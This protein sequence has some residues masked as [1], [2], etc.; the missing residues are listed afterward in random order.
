MDLVN[1]KVVVTEAAT[2][3]ILHHYLLHHLNINPLLTMVDTNH[4]LPLLLNSLLALIKD[5]NQA[6]LLLTLRYAPSR[7]SSVPHVRLEIV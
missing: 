3:L 4:L 7:G 1:S 2:A 5:T 6:H